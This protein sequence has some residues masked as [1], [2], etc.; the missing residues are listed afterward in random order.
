MS[1]R[2]QPVQ[3]CFRIRDTNTGP[4]A[5][6]ELIHLQS[7]LMARVITGVFWRLI[8]ATSRQLLAPP[9]PMYSIIVV[10][11]CDDRYQLSRVAA[12]R[13]AEFHRGQVKPEDS[14]GTIRV[15]VAFVKL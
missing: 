1:A 4:R 8:A 11:S 2:T 14:I 10:G 3:T 13:R 6:L 12:P 15:F 5:G 9:S 7:D